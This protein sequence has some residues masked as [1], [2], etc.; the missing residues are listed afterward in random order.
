MSRS[1]LVF[2]IWSNPVVVPYFVVRHLF[3]RVATLLAMQ[4]W[5][6]TICHCA[7]FRHR[8]RMEKHDVTVSMISS[9]ARRVFLFAFLYDDGNIY[10]CRVP[11]Q[12]P[13]SYC[14]SERTFNKKYMRCINFPVF[15][16]GEKRI[17]LLIDYY[18]VYAKHSKDIVLFLVGYFCNYLIYLF[19]SLMDSLI[20][21]TF[22]Q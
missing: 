3:Q 2:Q 17:K 15:A 8:V 9:L 11:L 6:R 21:K 19:K 20:S 1:L 22:N 5:L 7:Q 14:T 10:T 16:W 18:R 4:M 13:L 12:S